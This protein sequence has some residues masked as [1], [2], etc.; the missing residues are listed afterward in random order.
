MAWIIFVCRIDKFLWREC[1]ATLLTLVAISTFCATTRTCANDVAVGKEFSCY[2]ITE[3]L[4][5]LFLQ[6]ALIVESAEE[7]RSKLVMNIGSG[8]AINI[9]RNTEILERFLDEVMIAVYHL[10]HGDALFLSTD[11]NRHSMLVRTS[12]KNNFFLL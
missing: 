3:L 4:L 7:V 6:Y 11:S 1:S 5:Y 10:L 12:N 2:L 9:E 8:T